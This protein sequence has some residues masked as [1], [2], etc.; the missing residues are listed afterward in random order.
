M[1]L[2]DDD[3]DDLAAKAVQGSALSLERVD[4]VHG[5]DRLALGVLGVGDGVADHVLQED[6]EHA[7]RLLVDEAA[8]ALDTAASRQTT[9]RRL[10]DALNVVA[11]HFS[12]SLGAS[13]S[14]TFA[15]FAASRHDVCLVLLVVVVMRRESFGFALFL[16]LCVLALRRL[17]ATVCV[18]VSPT[19][20]V[21]TLIYTRLLATN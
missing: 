9:N 6:L 16:L 12:V 2:N 10:G 13:L 15:S 17:C 20:V 7:A 14:Q 1:R 5:G 8:E 21:A 18:C 3:D 11:Q 4:D 19:R